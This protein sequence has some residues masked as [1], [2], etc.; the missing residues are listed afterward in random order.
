MSNSEWAAPSEADLDRIYGEKP[1]ITIKDHG[2]ESFVGPA[3][4]IDWLIENILPR[5]T[6]SLLCSLGGVGKS[7]LMLDLC[8]RISAGPGM[9]PQFA[10]GGRIPKRGRTVFITAEDSRDAIHRRI[11]QLLVADEMESDLQKAKLFDWMFPIS[12]A[13]SENGL[14][15]LLSSHN[16]EYVMTEAWSDLSDQIKEIEPDLVVL[17]PLQALV[18]GDINADPACA[19]VFWSAVSRLCSQT[20]CSLL[21]T[22]HMRKAGLSSEVDGPMAARENIRGTTALVD[23]SRWTYALFLPSAKERASVEQA[24]GEPLGEMDLVQGCVVKSNDIGMTPVRHFIRDKQSGLLLDRT[25]QI[26]EELEAHLYLSDEQIQE[27]FEMVS[28]RWRRGDP[29]S[30][31]GIAKARYLGTWMMSH[32]ELNKEAVKDYISEWLAQGRLVKEPHPTI[33]RAQGLRYEP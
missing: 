29:F 25:D 10:L 17:D 15:S 11:D 31:S 24:L 12:L 26:N 3:P 21:A 5:G 23:G 4:K 20:G 27:T 13:D 8:M 7:Y 9:S 18:Q 1:W 22:H 14:R 28:T 19:Q 32:F 6:P 30:H 16:G 33:S 2:M